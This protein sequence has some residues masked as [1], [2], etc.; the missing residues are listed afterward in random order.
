MPMMKIK[1]AATVLGVSPDTVRRH[2][3]AGKLAAQRGNDGAWLV[4][5][6]DATHTAR[7]VA[8]AEQP[9]LDLQSIMQMHQQQVD[10]MR[11]D[12]RAEIDRLTTAHRAEVARLEAHLADLRGKGSVLDRLLHALRGHR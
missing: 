4:Q 2:V 7:G 8:A 6:P 5:V 10:Q 1:E 9:G 3:K 11:V 12:N